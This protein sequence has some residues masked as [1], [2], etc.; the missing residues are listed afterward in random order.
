MGRRTFKISLNELAL[1]IFF[2]AGSLRWFF[3]GIYGGIDL[4]IGLFLLALVLCIRGKKIEN[5][6]LAYIWILY[7]F[8]LFLNIGVHKLT[9]GNTIKSFFVIFEI[10][11]FAIIYPGGMKSFKKILKIIMIYGC[12]NALF[13]IIHYAMGDSFIN[14]YGAFLTDAGMTVA[15]NYIRLGH[16]FGF[17]YLPADT[18]GI[19]SFTLIAIIFWCFFIN[20][21]HRKIKT[22]YLFL[23]VILSI[24][25]L[26]TGKKG[27]LFISIIAFALIVL[28]IY[29][30][31]KQWIKA[32]VFVAAG[33]IAIFSLYIFIINHQDIELFRRLNSFFTNLSRGEDYDSSRIVVWGYAIE[34]WKNSKLFGIGWK[35]F[36]SITE[37][38]YGSAHEVNC[39]YLQ[40]LCETG[41]LGAV[42]T[43]I[44]LVIMLYRTVITCKRAV[45]VIENPVQKWMVLCCCYFQLFVLI[46]AS[47][48]IPFYD[49]T[50]FSMFILTGIVINFHYKDFRFTSL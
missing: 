3:S 19:I 32:I 1:F 15:K 25:L 44:P 34:A 50:F 26:L 47:M 11:L 18:A 9:D 8:N 29:A 7:C 23:I 6:G 39:D 17:N 16:Y 13:V 27:I 41:I 20:S 48:E 4:Q 36:S 22:P 14:F 46:Y 12:L 30:S 2:L 24:A 35:T 10:I 42:L 21:K 31:R 37:A 43:L 49:M 28:L 45:R 40:I 33:A 5:N 38:I